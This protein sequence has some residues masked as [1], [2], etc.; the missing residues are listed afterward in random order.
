MC[1]EVLPLDAFAKRPKGTNPSAYCRECQRIYC[2]AHYLRNFELHNRRRCV[3]TR[4]YKKRNRIL[5]TAYLKE[6]PCVDCGEGDI[7]V[8]DFDHAPGTK[9]ANISNLVGR[10][11]SWQRIEEEMAKCVV[12]CANCHRRK[13]AVDF[14]WYKD[15]GIGA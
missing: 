5:M 8:L 11:A 4:R 9:T 15:K 14:G 6:H 13:T 7:R 10:G 2:R 3:N 12:R 1:K